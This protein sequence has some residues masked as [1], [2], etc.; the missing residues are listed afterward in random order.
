MDEVSPSYL[1]ALECHNNNLV[2]GVILELFT[3]KEGRV[4]ISL[5]LVSR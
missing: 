1:E 4:V 5:R 2:G 3:T